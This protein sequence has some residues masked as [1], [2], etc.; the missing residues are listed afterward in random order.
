VRQADVTITDDDRFVR[1]MVT[2]AGVGFDLGMVGDDKL[3][4]KESVVARL[5]EVGGT[6][7]LFSSPGAGTTVV[8]EVAK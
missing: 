7:R 6:A 5:Y 4:Y 2:D 1:A 8:L 3:G